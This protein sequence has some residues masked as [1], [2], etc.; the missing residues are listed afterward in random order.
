MKTTQAGNLHKVLQYIFLSCVILLGFISIIGTGGG[1]GDGGSAQSQITYTGINTQAEITDT[2]A[3]V[4]AAGAFEGGRTGSAFSGTG[5]VAT[6]LDENTMSFRTLKV[7]QALKGAIQQVDLSFVSGDPIIGATQSESGSVSGPCGGTASY[8]IQY[9]DATGVFS[10]TFTFNSYCDT[11]VVIS[12]SATVSGSVDIVL[13][14]FESISFDFTNLS[15]GSS[16]LSGYI[17]IDF[18]DG[19]NIRV[20]LDILLKDNTTSKVY[21][22]SNYIMYI[23]IGSNY[24]DANISFGFYY[25]PD[26]GY[27]AVETPTPFRVFDTDIWPSSGVMIATGTGNT[28]ARLTSISNTQCQI[29]ADLD[30]DDIYEWGPDTKNWEDL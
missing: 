29:D 15:D 12:G 2:N 11:G 14:T 21:W 4:I 23:T 22:V 25:D 18:T 3:E 13:S 10:G 5:A 20:D 28:K 9:D 27:V 7:T 6:G 19:S 24:A 17:D 26:Y 16:T 30:D 8:S 1:G